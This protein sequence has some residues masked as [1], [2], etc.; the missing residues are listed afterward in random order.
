MNIGGKVKM[1]VANAGET[2]GHLRLIQAR[3]DVM[4]EKFRTA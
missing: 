3:S 4:N 2:R 1:Q